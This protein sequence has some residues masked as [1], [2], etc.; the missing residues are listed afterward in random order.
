M[1]FSL[2]IFLGLFTI[3]LNNKMKGEED[4]GE[5]KKGKIKKKIEKLKRIRELEEQIENLHAKLSGNK[6][7][8]IEVENEIKEKKKK[9]EVKNEKDNEKIEKKQLF[10]IVIYFLI[11]YPW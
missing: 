10:N 1:D 11:F 8:K 6:Q 4:G 3:K 5:K 2:Q 7:R 9:D